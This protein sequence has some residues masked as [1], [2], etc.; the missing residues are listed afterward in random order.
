MR[1]KCLEAS[2]PCALLQGPALAFKQN[3]CPCQRPRCKGLHLLSAR[4][5]TGSLHPLPCVPV[6]LDE[7]KVDLGQLDLGEQPTV[8][9]CAYPHPPSAA[10]LHNCVDA[11]SHARLHCEQQQHECC[12]DCCAG[13]INKIEVGA[14]II[15]RSSAIMLP[16]NLSAAGLPGGVMGVR[17][18]MG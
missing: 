14:R 3:D 10:Q 9:L 8:T 17:S 6:Q 13:E 15:A 18:F 4:V 5:S 12:L 7:F 16:L 1:V 11:L 2:M